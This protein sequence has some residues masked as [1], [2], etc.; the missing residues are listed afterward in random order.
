MTRLVQ[1]AAYPTTGDANRWNELVAVLRDAAGE[2]NRLTPKNAELA[3]LCC[4]IDDAE[5]GVV[6]STD[7]AQ[8]LRQFFERLLNRQ[9]P[10]TC[11]TTRT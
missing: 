1:Q 4:A 10:T 2:I 7:N 11:E 5:L 9:T 6:T 8:I 3:A